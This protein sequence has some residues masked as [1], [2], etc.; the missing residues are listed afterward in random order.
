MLKLD[1]IIQIMNQIDHYENKK[2]KKIIGLMKDYL[3]GKIMTKYVGLRAKTYSY[4]IHDSSEDKTV[5]GTKNCVIKRELNVE[6]Y[7]NYK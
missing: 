6:N 7:K 3:G 2:I 1:L 4:L 5:N